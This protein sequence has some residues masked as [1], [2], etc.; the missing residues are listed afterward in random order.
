M[1]IIG[2]VQLLIWTQSTYGNDL[3]VDKKYIQYRSFG[4]ITPLH[5]F[6]YL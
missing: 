4:A 5:I 6:V 3:K 1:Y 2:P